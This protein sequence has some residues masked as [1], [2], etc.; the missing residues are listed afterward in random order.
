VLTPRLFV[1]RSCAADE[2]PSPA[3]AAAGGRKRDK[4]KGFLKS[5]FGK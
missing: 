3:A 1:R 2:T 4:A 5:L